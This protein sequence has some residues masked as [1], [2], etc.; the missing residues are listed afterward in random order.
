MDKRRFIQQLPEVHNTETLKKFFGATVD[1]IFQPGRSENLSGYIGS[2]PSYYDSEKDFYVSEPTAARSAYQL[3]PAMVSTADSGEVTNL[4]TYDDLMAYLRSENAV[5]NDHDRMF[6]DQFYGWVPPVDLDKLEN[7]RQYYWFGDAP[8]I[9]PPVVLKVAHTE[10]AADG[11]THVFALPPAVAGIDPARETPAAFVDSLPVELEVVGNTVALVEVPPA[12]AAVH[13]FRYADLTAVLEGQTSFDPRPFNADLTLSALSSNMRVRFEDGIAFFQGFGRQPYETIFI[14]IPRL[15]KTRFSVPWDEYTRPSDFFVEGVGTSI[16]VVPYPEK[17]TYKRTTATYSCIDR[18]SRERSPWAVNNFWVHESAFRWADV[19]FP[20]RRAARPIIE[21]LPNLAIGNYG[22]RRLEDISGTLTGDPLYVPVLLDKPDASNGISDWGIYPFDTEA[23][24]SSGLRP[25]PLIQANGKK[26]GQLFVDNAKMLNFGDRILVIQNDF[27]DLD[28]AIIRVRLGTVSNVVVLPNGTEEIQTENVMVLLPEPGAVAGDTVRLEKGRNVPWDKAAGTDPWFL[29]NPGADQLPWEYLSEA[30]EFHYE[31][32]IWKEAQAPHADQQDPLFALFTD[33]GVRHDKLTNSTFTGNRLF[34]YAPATVETGI[35][36]ALLNRYVQYDGQSNAL[37]F[38][39]DQASQRTVANGEVQGFQYFLRYNA[40]GTTTLCNSW[41]PTGERT[42]Q[43]LANGLFSTPLNLLANPN[44]DEVSV[45]SKN[46]WLENFTNVFVRQPGFTGSPYNLNNW[47]D[48]ARSFGTG[49]TGPAWRAGAAYAI[50]ATCTHLG[51]VY[52]CARAHTS[53]VAFEAANWTIRPIHQIIQ[54]KSPLLR[55]MLLASDRRFD[56]LDAARFLDAEYARFRNK[57]RAQTTEVR[58]TGQVQPGADLEIWVET[59]LLNLRSTKTP[60]FAFALSTMAG[61]Q[62]FIPPTAAHMGILNVY[63]PAYEYDDTYTPAALFLRGHD[64]SRTP[65]TGSFEDDV[66]LALERRIWRSILAEFKTEAKRPFDFYAILDGRN[67][68]D[69]KGD[70]ITSGDPN[71]CDNDPTPQETGRSTYSLAEFVKVATP[72]FLRWAQ[73]NGIDY[74]SHKDYIPADPFTWNYRDQ[75]DRDGNKMPGNWRAIYRWYYDTDRPHACPWEMLGFG[76]KPAWWDNQYGAAPYTAGNAALWEDLRD[77]RIRQGVRQGI[78]PLFARPDLLDVLPVD[79]DG[80]LLN[81]M[82]IGIFARPPAADLAAREWVFGDGG[83]GEQLW[84]LSA[85]YRFALCQIGYLLRPAEWV[86][87]TWDTV[88]FRLL[89]DG[90]VVNARTHNRTRAA[91]NLVHGEIRNSF[92]QERYAFLGIQ[93]WISDLMASRSQSPTILGDALRHMG[94]Q[95]IHKM[96]GFTQA[97]NLRVFA[98]NFGILPEENVSVIL[99]NSPPIRE[100]VYSGVI[101]EWTGNGYSV[102]GYDTVKEGFCIEKGDDTSKTTIISLG[103]EPEIYEWRPNVYYPVNTLVDYRGSTF[104]SILAHTAGQTFD[105]EFWTPEPRKNTKFPKVTVYTKGEGTLTY[106]PYGTVFKTIQ[107]VASFLWDYGRAL[108]QEGFVFD[109]ID[110]QT[111]AI[112]NWETMVREFL[113]WA[114][115]DW[116]PGNFIA[117]SPGASQLKYV[118][119]HGVVYNVEETANGIYGLLNRTGRPIPAR[120]TFVSRLDEE[121]KVI[122]MSNDLFCARLRVGEIE[123]VVLF[124]NKTIFNDTIYEPLLTLRQ[125]RLRLFG[126]R[127]LNWSGRLDAPGYM[128]EQDTIEP[129]F[130]RAAENIREMFNVEG[131]EDRALRDFSRHVLGYQKRPYLDNLLVSETEQFEFYQGAIKQKGTPGV[132]DKLT[133]SQIVDRQSNL[134]FLEEWGFNIGRFGALDKSRRVAFVMTRSDMRSNPQLVQFGVQNPYDAVLDLPDSSSRW[135]EKPADPSNIFAYRNDPPEVIG[136]SSPVTRPNARALKTAGPVHLSEVTYSI[137]YPYLIG[138]LYAAVRDEDKT[139][140]EQTRIWVYDTISENQTYDVLRLDALGVG[141][142]TVPLVL[143]ETYGDQGDDNEAS[144]YP[145]TSLLQFGGKHGLDSLDIGRLILIPNSIG[146]TSDVEGFHV[147]LDVPDAYSVVVG[148]DI[149]PQIDS[150]QPFCFV[151]RSV[152]FKTVVERDAFAA[153]YGF[154]AGELAYVDKVPGFYGWVVF[155]WTGDRFEI[156]RQQPQKLDSDRLRNAVVYGLES[157][158][159][160]SSLLAQP[161]KLDGIVVNDPISGNICGEAEREISFRVDY[162][163]A[164][165]ANPAE[166][167]GAEH[168]GKLWWDTGSAMFLECET[169]ILTSSDAARTQR[170]MDHRVATWGRIAPG[171][172]INVWEWTRVYITPEEYVQNNPNAAVGSDYNMVTEYDRALDKIVTVY[173][174]WL[175]NPNT[176]PQVESRRISAAQVAQLIADPR[177]SDVPWVAPIA[178]NAMLLS[179][180]EQFLNDTATV[181]QFELSDDAYEGVNHEEFALVRKNDPDNLPPKFLY[182]LLRNSLTQFDDFVRPVPDTGLNAYDRVGASRRNRRTMIDQGRDGVL[183]GRRSFVEKLN[184]IMARQPLLVNQ[185]NALSQLR[186]ETPAYEKLAWNQKQGE[187]WIEAP[188]RGTYDFVVNGLDERRALLTTDDY[189]RAIGFKGFDTF[190][191]D[192][193]GWDY[194]FSTTMAD[195]RGTRLPR[196]LMTNYAGDTPSWSI[197]EAEASVRGPA[198]QKVYTPV[199]DPLLNL[200]PR[201]RDD[202][203]TLQAGA[204]WLIQ[205]PSIV[206]NDS[207]PDGDR[208]TVTSVG[209]VPPGMGTVTRMSATTWLY[210]SS[211]IA[212]GSVAIPYAITDGK[213]GVAGANIIFNVEQPERIQAMPNTYDAGVNTPLRITYVDLLAN[214]IGENIVFV[215]ATQPTNG[216]VLE[217]YNDYLVYHPPVGSAS[218]IDYFE[219]TIRSPKSGKT[220]S[221]MVTVNLALSPIQAA[222]DAIFINYNTSVVTGFDQILANDIGVG[223]RVAAVTPGTYGAPILQDDGVRYTAP[224]IVQRDNPEEDTFTYTIEDA[225]GQTSTANV[226]VYYLK[227][228]VVAKDDAV[229]TNYGTK[230]VLPLSQFTVNDQGNFIRVTAVGTPTYGSATL[231]PNG[232]EYVSP[233][234]N[235]NGVNAKEDSFPYTITDA[236]GQTATAIMT[237]AYNQPPIIRA[238][239]DYYTCAYDEKITIPFAELLNND[240]GQGR[241]VTATFTPTYGTTRQIQ[242]GVEYT[243]PAIKTEGRNPTSDVFRYS[244]KDIYGQTSSANVN[245]TLTRNPIQANDDLFTMTRAAPGEFNAVDDNIDIFM[246]Q[247]TLYEG[248]KNAPTFPQVSPLTKLTD[249]NYAVGEMVVI[250]NQDTHRVTPTSTMDDLIL[251]FNRGYMA[252]LGYQM[253]IIVRENGTIATGDQLGDLAMGNRFADT[254]SSVIGENR[255]LF[256]YNTVPAQFLTSTPNVVEY[257]AQVFLENDKGVDANTRIIAI[258]STQYVQVRLDIPSQTIFVTSPIRRTYEQPEPDVFTYTIQKG[259]QKSTATITITVRPPFDSGIE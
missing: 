118:T 81:P 173:Y 79:E 8:Q 233:P 126:M 110:P 226:K 227:P 218:S 75:L 177:G 159:T 154:R 197:W 100:A 19:N 84:M 117:L 85:S 114:Q 3:E 170:Q 198:P 88:N 119:A 122:T 141:D 205:A 18:R 132:F 9:L 210:Q 142:V 211:E 25:L 212:N 108:E 93:Q 223:L 124:S 259:D 165:Y 162:D 92:T 12:G 63:E 175:R 215:G 31:D 184:E 172:S 121:T 255:R 120:N 129:N 78:D 221:T 104:R 214:D 180:V 174:F 188:P 38:S 204:S 234:F 68:G 91:D 86:E 69:G 153:K 201:A 40:D 1:H 167:W 216:G 28:G 239:D 241:Q 163:P 76:Q 57:F 98:D 80:K 190:K 56:Y 138:Q 116:Q 99:H 58:R 29:K 217:S 231:R 135:I 111:G 140:T 151:V 253:A 145:G 61:G 203:Y 164:N 137:A 252:S 247:A 249:L 87:I 32:G 155:Q 213:G 27:P 178:P 16:E 90:Q 113:A 52:R 150:R 248:V 82:Q 242:T 107:E 2:K 194:D 115:M 13:V 193:T 134:A 181:V 250:Y 224:P 161:L 209:P 189:L 46:Q 199:E 179:N 53:G 185:P 192:S 200:G 4:L 37:K 156:H 123:H 176:V 236:F 36:D 169:D 186:A 220:S 60:E 196:I 74:R 70:E 128:V 158:I 5:T 228:Q 112:Q 130:W 65:V 35:V 41:Y 26:V 48:S 160:D 11:T 222:D 206:A 219:Y 22:N 103:D 202:S 131:S 157:E 43:T 232:V 152:K 6:G 59:V 96:A 235:A 225:Y 106:V 97:Q 166:R 171:C 148:L 67:R 94:V 246:T 49:F 33:E 144:L 127:T 143:V 44:H 191:Y 208:L 21:I 195:L 147:I 125:P 243:P 101:I 73:L 7:Y 207:D 95:M 238:N 102:I 139:F 254:D 55:T 20:S 24:E 146:D 182:T 45:I 51:K 34:G 10:Y 105:D 133:R 251:A 50:G 109:Y 258:G 257:P 15:C 229:T 187:D 136:S 168:V 237:L 244:I 71:P 64:G 240:V 72:I 54:N 77:G 62:Y 30:I 66:L 149:D 47:R 23:Y 230:I 245:I 39:F 83:P 89:P 14:K 42:H 256:G 183:A 17:M